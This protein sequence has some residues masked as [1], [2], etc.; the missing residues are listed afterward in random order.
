MLNYRYDSH[1]LTIHADEAGKEWIKTR[2]EV[3]L[4]DVEVESALFQELGLTEINDVDRCKLGALTSASIVALEPDWEE[5][6]DREAKSDTSSIHVFWDSNYAVQSMVD[7]LL[8]H[9][10]ATLQAG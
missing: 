4:S 9:G 2:R 3:G 6:W 8:E 5:I 1:S 10:E 7:N